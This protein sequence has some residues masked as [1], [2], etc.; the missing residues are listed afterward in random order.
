VPPEG[1]SLTASDRQRGF[2]LVSVLAILA[3]LAL[4]VGGFALESRRTLAESR[5]ALEAARGRTRAEAGV[6][7]AIAH[8]IDPDPAHRWNDNGTTHVVRF[9]G[10]DILVTLQD[11]AGEIDLNWAP[12]E[13]V[14]NLLAEAGAAGDQVQSILDAIAARR[15]AGSLPPAPPGEASGA[16]QLGGPHLKDLATAPFRLVE[17]LKTLPGVDQE[18]FDRIRPFLTVYAQRGRIDPASAPRAVLLALPGVTAEDADTILAARTPDGGNTRPRLPDDALAYIGAAD[19]RAVTII[20]SAGRTRRRAVISL[21]GRPNQ[22]VQIL[23][24]RQEFAD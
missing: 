7:L 6:S 11:E 12:L 5:S 8:L 16:A 1:R 2:A 15:Q 10:T 22:P 23:E 13:V 19:Q 17:D 3:L 18:L 4:L 14:G 9:D 20:A 24:W 21:T